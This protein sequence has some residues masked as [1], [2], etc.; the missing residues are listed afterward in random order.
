MLVPQ[1]EICVVDAKMSKISF[2]SMFVILMLFFVSSAGINIIPACC[3]TEDGQC[4]DILVSTSGTC[5]SDH[6]GYTFLSNDDFC[7]R[8]EDCC[9]EPGNCIPGKCYIEGKLQKR[10]MFFLSCVVTCKEAGVCTCTGNLKT[11]T[12]DFSWSQN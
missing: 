11:C 6:P 4:K 7:N 1:G 2:Y 8:V 10:E 9:Y 5:G 12:G 3:A